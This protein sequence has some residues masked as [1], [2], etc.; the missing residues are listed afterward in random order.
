MWIETSKQLPPFDVPVWTSMPSG[1]MIIAERS[2]STDGWMW[3]NCYG[4]AY[5]SEGAW[6]SSECAIDD[7]Y[8]PTHWQYLPVP[9]L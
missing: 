1:E 3:G 2:S 4:N 8:E 5:F 9:P 6:R 7:D